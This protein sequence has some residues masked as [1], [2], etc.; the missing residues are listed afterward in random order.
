VVHGVGALREGQARTGFVSLYGHGGGLLTNQGET[1]YTSNVIVSAIIDGAVG[2]K[3]RLVSLFA[4]L[5]HTVFPPRIAFTIESRPQLYTGKLLPGR[6]EGGGCLASAFFYFWL[7]YLGVL[8]AALYIAWVTGRAI[9]HPA[10]LL[11][12]Y[13]VGVYSYYPRWLVYDAVSFLFRVP[14]Y[15]IFLYMGAVELHKIVLESKLARE[16]PIPQ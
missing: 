14:L 1:F 2:P 11:S 15:A 4:G 8:L 7:D 10:P 3:E 13:I 16:K 6:D 9:K 12:I 5:L